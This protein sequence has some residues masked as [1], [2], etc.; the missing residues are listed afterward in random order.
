MEKFVDLDT[1]K[2]KDVEVNIDEE[3]KK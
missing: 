1:R 2:A 3:L